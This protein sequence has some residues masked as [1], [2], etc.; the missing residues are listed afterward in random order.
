MKSTPRVVVVGGGLAG[1]VAARHL[2]AGGVDVTLTERR[3]SVGGRVRT[4][5]RDGYQFDD[6]FQV[7]F[8]AYPAVRRELDLEALDLRPF[9]PGATIARDGH[10]SPL[11]DPLRVPRAFPAALFTPTSR[12]GTNSAWRDSGGR[13]GTARSTNSSSPRR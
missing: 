13:S 10:R 9:A 5:V 12:S 3:P 6:G 2:A 8:T 11:V 7:L 1:L 4:T